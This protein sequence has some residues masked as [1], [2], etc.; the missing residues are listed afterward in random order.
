MR[1]Q[2]IM[3]DIWYRWAVTTWST[4]IFLYILTIGMVFFWAISSVLVVPALV[5]HLLIMSISVQP[6][7][8]VGPKFMGAIMFISIPL[9]WWIANFVI[10]NILLSDNPISMLI[11]EGL[12]LWLMLWFFYTL[13]VC[14]NGCNR[15]SIYL[16]P[17]VATLAIVLLSVSICLTILCL[18]YLAIKL[19]NSMMS[20]SNVGPAVNNLDW[21]IWQ[22]PIFDGSSEPALLRCGHMFHRE[23][24]EHWVTQKESCP[25]DRTATSKN[26]IIR[27]MN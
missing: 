11:F 16:N 7:T 22:D 25:I 19:W 14:T 13:L 1:D 21:S 20:Q 24:I 6:G 2:Y 26:Q 10:I 18:P 17:L 9:I 23:C 8:R 27:V 15:Y 12:Y 3:R 4:I 5:F